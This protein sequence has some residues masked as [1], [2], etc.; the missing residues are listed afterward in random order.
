MHPLNSEAV[1]YCVGRA[2]LLSAVL[3]LAA[4][5]L[6]A[7]AAAC[8]SA[9]GSCA[10]RLGALLLL[11]LA[12][13]CKETALV[14][15]P[16]CAA[17]DLLLAPPAA[18][19]AAADAADATGTAGGGAPRLWLRRTWLRLCARWAPLLCALLSFAAVR[20]YMAGSLRHTFRRLDNPLAFLPPGRTNLLTLLSYARVHAAGLTLLVW[21]ATLSADYS[22]AAIPLATRLADV[23]NLPAALTYAGGAALSLLLL[24][25]AKPIELCRQLMSGGAEGRAT[26]AAA[27]TVAAPDAAAAVPAAALHDARALL[28]WWVLLLLAY[29]PASHVAAPLAFVVAE[30]R[31]QPQ[32]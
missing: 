22:H 20:I 14:L 12:L 7:L 19:A 8:R 6:H 10:V 13:G 31:L 28:W 25:R 15:L 1:A 5:R 9:V 30:R 11:L 17:W 3:G 2:D 4:L 27:A 18:M 16:A 23:A 24:C 32:P 26:A 21:P 29:A